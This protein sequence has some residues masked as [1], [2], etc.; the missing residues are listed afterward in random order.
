MIIVDAEKA[1]CSEMESNV[2][3][4]AAPTMDALHHVVS[5]HMMT[6]LVQITY[7]LCD[8]WESG[9]KLSGHF[10]KRADRAPSKH[11]VPKAT[12]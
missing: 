6:S 2:V 7:L 4:L 1:L 8:R 5:D 11:S 3:Y 12:E 10:W 9:S